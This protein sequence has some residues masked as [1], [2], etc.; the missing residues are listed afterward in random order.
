MPHQ[1]YDSE[2]RAQTKTFLALI[3][4]LVTH[5]STASRIG[6]TTAAA[7]LLPGFHAEKNVLG[8]ASNVVG[9]WHALLFISTQK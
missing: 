1:D 8:M 6:H 9:A 4:T 7:L 5:T 2:S 3:Q